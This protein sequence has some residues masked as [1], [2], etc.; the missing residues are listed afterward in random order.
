MADITAGLPTLSPEDIQAQQD[1]AR[2]AALGGTLGAGA[3]RLGAAFNDIFTMPARAV[4]GAANTAL[5]VPNA[6]GAGI[7]YI[8]DNG[9]LSSTTPYSDALTAR[10]VPLAGTLPAMTAPAPTK[11]GG[12]S[13]S[14][15]GPVTVDP[16]TK[17][18]VPVATATGT[19]KSGGTKNPAGMPAGAPAPLVPGVTGFYMNDQLVPYGTMFRAS[20]DGSVQQISGA[21]GGGG[22]GAA[23]GS[24]LMANL[25]GGG[26]IANGRFV[27]PRDALE[28]GFRLQ[29]QYRD[30]SIRAILDNAGD[31]S[32]LGYRARVGALAQAFGANN[33]GQTSVG[34][35]N[36]LNQA[37]A[38]I[39]GAEIGAG[40]TIGAANIGLKGR[41]AE[42]A[43]Q[44]ELHGTDSVPTGTVLGSD[45]LTHM[46]VPLTTYGQRPTKAGAM[47]LSYT[48]QAPKPKD[49][50]TGK[51][52][53]GRAV[54][55]KNGEWQPAT[56]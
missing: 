32:Q 39:T 9:L 14:F 15:E 8:P 33:F 23:S 36:A 28:Y 27:D 10:G 11:G 46:A 17:A 26:A 47:P 43:A 25:P 54:V 55:Y 51:T 4:M 5:R 19:P 6:F 42:I 49:G 50:A 18:P 38:H 45:P 41:E 44:R 30:D 3:Q 53:D 34:G 1:R 22:G 56:K 37:L 12:A 13:G 40:A 52:P 2:L 16:T 29:S 48:E 35:A 21:G 20:G 24:K 31:G 7:P